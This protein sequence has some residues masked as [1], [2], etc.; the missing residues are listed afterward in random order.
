VLESAEDNNIQ[1][2][3]KNASGEDTIPWPS[4]PFV[5]LALLGVAFLVAFRRRR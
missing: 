3:T 5:L 4:A 2:V 1:L